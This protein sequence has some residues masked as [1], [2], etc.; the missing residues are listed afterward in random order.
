MDIS[1]QRGVMTSSCSEL[2]SVSAAFV[3]TD[4]RE[5]L[6][7]SLDNIND[8]HNGSDDE[9]SSGSDSGSVNNELH[10][11][12]RKQKL[13]AKKTIKR[14]KKREKEQRKKIE[15]NI[16]CMDDF[17]SKQSEYKMWLQEEKKKC[18]AE[19]TSSKLKTY[20]KTFVKL[21]NKKKLPLKYYRGSAGSETP[22]PT[23]NG[24]RFS[25]VDDSEDSIKVAEVTPLQPSLIGLVQDNVMLEDSPFSTFGK[26]PPK[27]KCRRN[28]DG[29]MQSPDGNKTDDSH[30]GSPVFATIRNKENNKKRPRVVPKQVS[31]P[32][33]NEYQIPKVQQ[34]P[35]V[36]TDQIS[37][38]YHIPEKVCKIRSSSSEGER[39]PLKRSLDWPHT[40]H[41]IDLVSHTGERF[42]DG[43]SISLLS[44]PNSESSIKIYGT[45]TQQQEDGD[46]TS[47]STISTDHSH[48]RS[49]LASIKD[50]AD[51]S[52]LSSVSMDRS[53]SGEQTSQLHESDIRVAWPSPPS[54][55]PGENLS[56][57]EYKKRCKNRRSSLP[58]PPPPPELLHLAKFDKPTVIEEEASFI[59]YSPTNLNMIVP[60]PDKSCIEDPGPTAHAASSVG[61][62]LPS[63][64]QSDEHV[65]G[66]VQPNLA[67]HTVTIHG[68]YEDVSSTDTGDC[69]PVIEDPGYEEISSILIMSQTTS[70]TRETSGKVLDYTAEEPVYA[71]VLKTDSVTGVKIPPLTKQKPKHVIPSPV[72]FIAPPT[73]EVPPRLY[74]LIEESNTADENNAQSV[75]NLKFDKL[76]NANDSDHHHEDK[77]HP[78][79]NANN[80]LNEEDVATLL[81][82]KS[83]EYFGIFQA[84]NCKNSNLPRKATTHMDIKL[85]ET[86]QPSPSK[87]VSVTSG[88]V[89]PSVLLKDQIP[90]VQC[91]SPSKILEKRT[92]AL[93][94]AINE[95]GID[96]SDKLQ[97][98][99]SDKGSAFKVNQNGI[100]KS[101]GAMKKM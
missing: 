82:A 86:I 45:H 24:Q 100:T 44:M 15:K 54:P 4:Q 18:I 3:K 92:L 66:L 30:G 46:N 68:H 36:I 95:T 101:K 14:D 6:G 60:Q 27:I 59:A 31:S 20:F 57:K 64:S 75:L 63:Q 84:Q 38:E 35:V 67:S 10:K 55:V 70:E 42:S 40:K 52:S 37:E 77:V 72:K 26:I 19:M 85:R 32:Q 48:S 62:D 90:I 91:L 29:I 69:L 25:F 47:I 88:E 58:P 56:Y 78:Q 71:Q 74:P 8:C 21:W 43:D 11:A 80:S 93:K 12:S 49:N 2:D 96:N 50:V 98:I 99:S 89:T 1:R 13:L 23:H 87:Q 83:R 7:M 33:I 17:L 76:I 65:R 9:S 53:S 94:H 5:I 97:E 61:F 41:S 28:V 51:N 22:T 79:E 73:P 39:S 16:I 34:K 81:R